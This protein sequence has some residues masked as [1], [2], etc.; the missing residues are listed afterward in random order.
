M[1]QHI[2]KLNNSDF[3]TFTKSTKPTSPSA[4]QRKG[5]FNKTFPCT[6]LGKLITFP[7]LTD[8]AI[9]HMT[10]IY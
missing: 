10:L 1:V 8:F 2:Y 7:L 5:T 6:K 4:A 9:V 3:K